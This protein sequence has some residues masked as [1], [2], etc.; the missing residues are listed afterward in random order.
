MKRLSVWL[1]C[2]I[3]SVSYSQN[4]K[5]QNFNKAKKVL[6]GLHEGL[7]S[8]TLYCD[9]KYTGRLVDHDSC[10]YKPKRNNERAKRV[11]WEHVVPAHAFGQSFKEWR[12]GHP[13]CVKKNGKKFKGRKCAKKTSREF[14]LM[15][16]D[17]YN[18]LPAIGEVNG[19][20]SNYSMAMIPGEPREFGK[21]DVE[22]SDNKIE[23]RPEIRGNIARIY[24]YM[25]HAYPNKG[26][27]SN[28]N[29]KLIEAW[30]KMD[31]IDAEEIALSQKIEQIQGN[32]NIFVTGKDVALKTR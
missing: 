17:L 29:K 5:I 27:I 26:I 13:E 28:K 31:P 4:Q 10:G 16:A 14:R 12:E 21:C 32:K 1:L 11:E 25:D 9:C 23:P 7:N 22:I 19:Y 30:H 15:E 6:W 3:S 8:R 24:M 18:L 20:R 2:L